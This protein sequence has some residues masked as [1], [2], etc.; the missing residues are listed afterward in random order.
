ML[1]LRLPGYL[2]SVTSFCMDYGFQIP[3]G[4]ELEIFRKLGCC[5]K[6]LLWIVF[7][8][9]ILDSTPQICDIKQCFNNLSNFI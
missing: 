6:I 7:M 3:T 5:L 2:L 1:V 9:A 8:K 4:V